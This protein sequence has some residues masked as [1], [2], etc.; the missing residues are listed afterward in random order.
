[1]RR[2]Q[3][4]ATWLAIAS[5]V[6]AHAS[7]SAQQPQTRDASHPPIRGTASIAGTIVADDDAHAPIRHATV[8]IRSA[9]RLDMRMT[10]TDESGRYLFRD[11][12]A[13]TYTMD[14]A[15]GAYLATSY[16]ALRPG[17]ADLGVP[18]PLAE[19]QAF[20]ARPMVLTRG[21][22]VTGR[23][24]DA[25]GR[26]V[27]GVGVTVGLL[28]IVNGDR[29]VRPMNGAVTDSRGIY[30]VFGLVP[31][32]Y[33][34]SATAPLLSGPMATLTTAQLQWLDRGSGAGAV[35]PPPSSRPLIPVPTFYPGTADVA[36]AGVVT[37]GRGEERADLDIAL[38][39]VGAANISGIVSGADGQP[40]ANA[41]VARAPKKI[42]SLT[43]SA[44]NL[45]TRS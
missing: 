42:G 3:S 35:P 40:F 36:A 2:S 26:P 21:S 19:G 24:L 6:I 17:G 14:A 45:Q 22:V 34:I 18:I 29:Q 28:T 7:G 5:I 30:R 13:A 16:G 11:L 20:V 9:G 8:T 43:G 15:K 25:N 27:A 37:L 44:L 33:L 12:P 31:G 39:R 38:V 23:L 1:M 4:G 41:I 32:D 10:A